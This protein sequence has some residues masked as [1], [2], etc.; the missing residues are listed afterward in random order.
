M[1]C[2]PDWLKIEKNK[3]MQLQVGD[4]EVAVDLED[5]VESL[6]TPK[7]KKKTSG[8]LRMKLAV[9]VNEV[10]DRE[11]DPKSDLV[12][13]GIREES[14]V[15]VNEQCDV[16]WLVSEEVTFKLWVSLLAT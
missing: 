1:T 5:H 11:I 2:T 3:W 7:E 9:S 16:W 13:V 15:R 14:G 12:C 8:V 10:T 4:G 6:L